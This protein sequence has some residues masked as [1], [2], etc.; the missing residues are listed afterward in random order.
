MAR[1]MEKIHILF[2]VYTQ[3]VAVSIFLMTRRKLSASFLLVYADTLSRTVPS[4]RVSA[5]SWA[6]GAQ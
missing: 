1:Y 3:F 2:S 4:G 5:V 6:R